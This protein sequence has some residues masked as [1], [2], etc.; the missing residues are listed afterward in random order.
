M[1]ITPTYEAARGPQGPAGVA[2]VTEEAAGRLWPLFVVAGVLSAA[3]G[4]LVLAY[5]DPSVKLLGV[6]LGI[7][8][9]ASGVLLIIRGL[10]GRS[11]DADTTGAILVGTL[12]VIAGVI[13]IRNPGESLALLAIA[14][15]LFLIVAGA[16]ALGQGL[17]HRQGRWGKLAKGGVLVAAGTVIVAWPD[18]SLTTLA[19]LAGISLIL[20]GVAEIAEGMLVRSLSRPPRDA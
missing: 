13:V 3:I 1:A 15:G 8:L 4:I 9:L 20:Q 10:A 7:D 5:P 12:A 11:G 17:V 16:I 2:Q 14:F 19:V 6:F 18:L